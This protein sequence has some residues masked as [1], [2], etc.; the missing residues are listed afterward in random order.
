VICPKCGE[1]NSANFRFCGMCGAALEAQRPAGAP[2]VASPPEIARPA[3][4]A[5]PP[6]APVAANAPT[7]TDTVPPTSGPSFLGLDRPFVDAPEGNGRRADGSGNQSLT[8]FNSFLEPDEPRIGLRRIVLLLVLLTA[9]GAAGWWAFSNYNK[10]GTSIQHSSQPAATKPNGTEVTA[11]NPG[12][13]PQPSPETPPSPDLHTAQPVAPEATTPAQSQS[14]S[15][16][17]VAGGKAETGA[18]GKSDLKKNRHASAAT[19][20]TAAR[21]APAA[22]RATS[23]AKQRP[24]PDDKGD[25]EFRKGEAY[26]YGRGMPEN[27]AEAVKNLKAS[28]AKQNAKARSAFG[29]MYATGHCVPRDLPTSYSW[30]ALALRADP[31]NQIL[32]KDL[33]AVWNQ[34]TPPER[35]MATKAKQ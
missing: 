34:M 21:P 30:F 14:A 12:P 17:S 31:S 35:Q 8:G 6:R 26:L 3:Q 22:A 5:V 10:T 15:P 19:L 32:E 16:V 25:M 9:L 28:S 4:T 20:V 23:N 24:A 11:N 1:D 18:Q 33:V 7:A 13:N 2:R 27:C 29:T